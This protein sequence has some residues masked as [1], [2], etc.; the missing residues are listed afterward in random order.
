MTKSQNLFFEKGIIVGSFQHPNP[1]Q[2]NYYL[3]KPK[4]PATYGTCII[5][6][7]MLFT[8][9]N[10]TKLQLICGANHNTPNETLN[11]KI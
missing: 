6:A 4:L 8:L 2:S 5:I 9:A 1:S 3:A 7:G 11:T 10:E